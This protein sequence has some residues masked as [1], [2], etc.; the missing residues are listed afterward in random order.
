[1]N[2]EKRQKDVPSTWI[3][4]TH[5]GDLMEFWAPSLSLWSF[6]G[7][8]QQMKVIFWLFLS[9]SLC[10]SKYKF[11]FFPLLSIQGLISKIKE[12]PLSLVLS[13]NHPLQILQTSIFKSYDWSPYARGRVSELI[14]VTRRWQQWAKITELIGS[15]IWQSG[16]AG[17]R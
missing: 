3:P 15:L 8:S 13:P 6:G 4:V 2:L 9:L 16:S 17:T 10:L 7:R 5:M 14:L 1:M 11:F 12:I